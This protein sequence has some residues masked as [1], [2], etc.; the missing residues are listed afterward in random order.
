[1]L[2]KSQLLDA[3]VFSEFIMATPLESRP[4]LFVIPRE[5][6]GLLGGD[7]LPSVQA[8]SHNGHLNGVEGVNLELPMIVEIGKRRIRTDHRTLPLI[9]L[10]AIVQARDEYEGVEELA[11]AIDEAGF[12]IHDPL[13]AQ[14]DEDGAREYLSYVYGIYGDKVPERKRISD[15]QPSTFQGQEVYYIVVAGHRRLRALQ[16]NE[17]K[18]VDVKVVR[19]VDALH[20]LILQAQE[21]T[22]KLLKDYE[23]A[24]Q[25][26]RLWAVSKIAE[27]DLTHEEFAR[28]M[29]YKPKVIARDFRYYKLPDGVKNYVVPRRRQDSGTGNT[30]IPDQPLMPFNVACQLGRLAEADA[31]EHDI[32][33]M[34]RRLFEEGI[35]SEEAASKRVTAYIREFR[36]KASDMTDIF[37]VNLARLAKGRRSRQ[38]ADRF[39]PMFD[40]AIAFFNRVK[41]SQEAGFSDPLE[42][43]VSYA[44]AATRMKTL[45]EVVRHLLPGMETILKEGEVSSI[46]DVFREMEEIASS[47][48]GIK[49][50]HEEPLID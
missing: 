4:E 19:G 1:M 32:L 9:E 47:F 23:R 34:A 12:V 7:F 27:P 38:V 41:Q 28:R 43:G 44:G 25:H 48:E 3:I 45:A 20:A 14:F 31:P 46:A 5:Q 33:F 29:G 21:N 30:V 36:S 49:N 8:P 26:G 13:V 22:P 18:D 37:G 50:G 40:N 11:G 2:L 16:I 15:L 6:M 39:S 10:N 42:D 17:A 35:S 24:E